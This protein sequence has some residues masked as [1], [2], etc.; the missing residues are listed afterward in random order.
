MIFKEKHIG[1]GVSI[2]EFPTLTISAGQINPFAIE[3]PSGYFPF[4]KAVKW[5]RK[6]MLKKEN[7]HYHQFYL[8][9]H[10]PAND[11]YGNEIDAYY[12][13]L[14]GSVPE[15]VYG[16]GIDETTIKPKRSG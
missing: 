5:A 3:E 14:K 10:Y 7:D 4:E 15:V 13:I 16:E 6:V 12:F 1:N 2:L 9:F 8:E 11:Y